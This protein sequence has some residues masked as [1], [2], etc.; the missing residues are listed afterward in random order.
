MGDSNRSRVPGP[1]DDRFTAKQ[2]REIESLRGWVEPG[3]WTDRMLEAL[4]KGVKGGVWFSLIDKVYKRKNLE[5]AAQRVLAKKGAA[6]VDHVSVGAYRSRLDAEVTQL[7]EALEQGRYRPQAIRRVYIEKV[8]SKE[9]RPLGIPTVRDRV[10]QR[11]L[12]HVLEP[13]FERRFSDRS[14]GYRPGRGPKDALREVDRY[15]RQGY[16]YVVEVDIASYFERIDHGLLMAKIKE[17]IADSR[18]L[19]L[20]EALLRQP[21]KGHQRQ[22]GKGVAQGAVTS[23]LWGN[24]YLNELDHHMEAKGYV[25]IRYADDLT[26]LCRSEEEAREALGHL[27]QWL[28][29]MKLE[30]QEEKTRIVH[31]SGGESGTDFLGYHFY[32]TPRGRIRRRPSG[33][34]IKHFKAKVRRQTSRLRGEGLDTII[35]GLNPLLRGWSEY[36]KQCRWKELE[37]LDRF[38]RQRLRGVLRYQSKRKGYVRYSDGFRW[39]NAYFEHHGLLAL[40]AAHALLRQSSSR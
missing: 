36:F 16:G 1:I 14:Y 39:P 24:I 37:E 15:L 7:A 3:V 40:T 18:V 30:T 6:G 12:L 17:E 38:V 8:G 22:A 23:P 34:S 5:M 19:S 33:K 2:E 31:L 32:R 4:V 21:V 11:A 26:V 13:I 35:A 29:G 20:I 27:R 28:E 9:K 10:V 25:M